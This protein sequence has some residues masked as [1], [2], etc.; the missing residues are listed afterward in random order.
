MD[1]R[2]KSFLPTHS[3]TLHK[4]AVRTDGV[5]RNLGRQATWQNAPLDMFNLRLFATSLNHIAV[6]RA[7]Q[8]RCTTTLHG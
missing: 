7:A 8:K 2:F 4:S 6:N 3:V 1:C 5:L